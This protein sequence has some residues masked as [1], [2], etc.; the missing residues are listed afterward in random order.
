MQAYRAAVAELDRGLMAAMRQRI[1][2]LER[3]GAP[4]VA[5]LW[6]EPAGRERMAAQRLRRSPGTGWAA[7]R[8]G[9][10]QLLPGG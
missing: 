4:P 10:R 7:V 2:E 8:A 9:A 3:R 5:P 1:E 6:R